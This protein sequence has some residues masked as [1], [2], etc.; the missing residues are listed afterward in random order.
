[1]R[2]SRNN[3]D[4]GAGLV[5]YALVVMFVGVVSMIAVNVVGNDTSDTFDTIAGSF[6]D[7]GGPEVDERTPDEKWEDAKAEYD[8]A[9]AEAKANKADDMAAAKDEYNSKVNENKK[10][11][12]SERNAANKE[13]KNEYNSA[14]SKANS[15]Y[16]S[17]VNAA[18]NARDQAK[19][20]WKASK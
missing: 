18:K 15:E 10:L 20:E 13:A 3:K 7:V 9:I 4:R 11:P 12:K 19:A 1:M 16:K 2:L 5:E 17:S 8:D 14:K 6:D